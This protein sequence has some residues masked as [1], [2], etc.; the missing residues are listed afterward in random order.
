M[1]GALWFCLGLAIGGW[2]GMGLMCMLVLSRNGSD[3]AME[4]GP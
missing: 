3:D 2:M 4:E 1:T